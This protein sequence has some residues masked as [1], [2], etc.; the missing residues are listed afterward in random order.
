MLATA[1][2]LAALGA[3]PAAAVQLQPAH[4]GKLIGSSDLIVAGTVKSVTD[5][6]DRGL[7]YTEVTISVASTAKKKLAARSDFKFRQY[8]LLA[9]RKLADGSSFLG[10]AP[11]GFPHWAQGEQVIAFLYKPASRTGLR[12]TVGLA[13][14][15]FTTLGG[16]TANEFGNRGLFANLQVSPGLLTPEESAMV[17]QPA[18]DVDATALL[19]LVNRAVAGQWVERGMMK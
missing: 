15:K 10:A 2:A 3:A 4:L 7:P 16:R 19:R 17:R 1:F 12:T 14:G 5:G 6:H 13:Q 9:P 18:G 8:G 11:D